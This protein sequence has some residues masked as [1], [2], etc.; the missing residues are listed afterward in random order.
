MCTDADPPEVAEGHR[1]PN[2][3]VNTHS[4]IADVIEEDDGSRGGW[5]F[6][7]AQQ[8]SNQSI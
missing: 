6:W 1:D 4:Q 7:C 8:G 5:I 3:T 2:R